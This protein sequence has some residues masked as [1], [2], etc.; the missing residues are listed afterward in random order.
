MSPAEAAAFEALPLARA[1]VRL[2]RADEGGK[3]ET[4]VGDRSSWVPILR[5][6]SERGATGG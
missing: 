5:G 4:G 6:L 3:V 1:A 2:R